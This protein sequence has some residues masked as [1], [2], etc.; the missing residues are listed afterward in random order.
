MAKGR[1]V[2]VDD[3]RDM[4][5]FLDIMLRREGYDVKTFASAKAAITHCAN[6][7]FDLVI[8]DIRMPGM[9]GVEFLKALK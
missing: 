8:S 7:G 2:V 6:S 4:R 1:I 5:D 3:E 9:D